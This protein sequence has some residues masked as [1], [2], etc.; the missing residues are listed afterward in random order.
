MLR[1][2][3]AWLFD[4]ARVV[5]VPRFLSESAAWGG[6]AGVVPFV[7]SGVRVCGVPGFVA[8]ASV[9]IGLVAVT[10]EALPVVVIEFLPSGGFPE[11]SLLGGAAGVVHPPGWEGQR[12]G[13]TERRSSECSL[14]AGIGQGGCQG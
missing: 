9:A 8:F 7:F 3:S 4:G 5:R 11:F 13:G 1:A 10:L 12:R 2:V 6:V 14:R